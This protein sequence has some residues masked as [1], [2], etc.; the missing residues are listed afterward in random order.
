MGAPPAAALDRRQGCDAGAAVSVVTVPD[1]RRR[2]HWRESAPLPPVLLND[3]WAV[4]ECLEAPAD[5]VAIIEGRLA[6]CRGGRG[7][8]ADGDGDGESLVLGERQ[9]QVVDR[10]HVGVVHPLLFR[11]HHLVLQEHEVHLAVGVD[12]LGLVEIHGG[13]RQTGTAMPRHEFLPI[14]L[15]R[16]LKVETN[17]IVPAH[18]GWVPGGGG[19]VRAL[20]FFF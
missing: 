5:V 12:A 19:F 2:R 9:G 1:E 20:V 7:Y 15:R 11:G 10:G 3:Q 16:R 4:D 18:G 6:A 14:C 8:V 17:R 13:I